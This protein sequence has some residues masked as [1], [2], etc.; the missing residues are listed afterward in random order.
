MAKT[1]KVQPFINPVP[2]YYAYYDKST[3]EVISIT[4]EKS[5]VHDNGI[6]ISETEFRTLV[7][8]TEPFSKYRIGYS[9]TPNG[10]TELSLVPISEHGYSF[11]SNMFEWITDSPTDGC[12]LIVTWDRNKKH[13]EFSLSS[14]CKDRVLTDLMPSQLV[15]FVTLETDFDFLIRTINLSTT[16]L[17]NSN[18]T[19]PFNTNLENKIDKISIATKLLFNT[20]GLLINE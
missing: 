10:K 13:W 14:E 7:S 11:R 6:E 20:Y 17:V 3:G 16:D 19:I 2:V 9:K 5:I 8:G 4:N 15:F 18:I 12:D 1:K